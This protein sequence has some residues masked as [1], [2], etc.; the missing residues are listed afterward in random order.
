M[1]DLQVVLWVGEKGDLPMIKDITTDELLQALDNGSIDYLFDARG[2]DSFRISHIV[3]ALNLPTSLVENG[4]G[5][6]E[7]KQARMVFYC[8][9]P[10]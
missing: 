2:E 8:T 5:L 10:T 1:K 3:G 4:E 7:N 9:S 6:P